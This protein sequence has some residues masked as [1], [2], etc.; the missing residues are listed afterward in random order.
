MIRS[1]GGCVQA[2]YG[3]PKRAPGP[4]LA[5]SVDE[6]EG[7][8]G[9]GSSQALPQERRF[10]LAG[11]KAAGRGKAANGQGSCQAERQTAASHQPAT[12]RGHC[13]IFTVGGRCSC[14]NRAGIH[15]QPNQLVAGDAALW[16]LFLGCFCI[17]PI[18]YSASQSLLIY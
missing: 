6:S 12:Q 14:C 5:G 10:G 13:A 9:V 17:S 11:N 3:G 7:W 15:S 8:A 4:I 18:I 1:W 2:M 16:A